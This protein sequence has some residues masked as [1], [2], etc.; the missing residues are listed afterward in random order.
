MDD[1]MPTG[2]LLPHLIRGSPRLVRMATGAGITWGGC[3]IT[4]RQDLAGQTHT[5]TLTVL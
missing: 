5:H 3:P 2:C 4:E 1:V